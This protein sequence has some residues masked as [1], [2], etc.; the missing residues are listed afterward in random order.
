VKEAFDFW[1][2]YAPNDYTPA[3]FVFKGTPLAKWSNIPDKLKDYEKKLE[4]VWDKVKEYAPVLKAKIAQS[5]IAQLKPVADVIGKL[6]FG[7]KRS[8]RRKMKLLNRL[9]KAI[10]KGGDAWDDFLA[11]KYALTAYNSAKGYLPSVDKGLRGLYNMADKVGENKER[12][13]KEIV[14]RLP[15]PDDKKNQ[16]KGVV[17]KIAAATGHGAKPSDP[18]AATP[19]AL[20]PAIRAAI[21]R[22]KAAQSKAVVHEAKESPAMEA[23]EEAATGKGRK[24]KR[25]PS[26]RNMMVAKLMREEKLSLGEASKKVSA[27][28][29]KSGKGEL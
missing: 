7:K 23:K 14:D 1:N 18:K 9:N 16:I 8:A 10:L 26:A 12:I 17:N 6:G 5:G 3:G 29:K 25:K 19:S 11:S 27:M 4:G 2:T 21:E 24:G 20:P 13:N 22:A 15:M 28:M